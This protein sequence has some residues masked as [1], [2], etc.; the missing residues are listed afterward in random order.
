[1]ASRDSDEFPAEFHR[2]RREHGGAPQRLNDDQLAELAEEERVDAG[3]DDYDP[4]EVPPAT[5]TD[6]EPEDIRQTEVYEEE[7]A[8]LRR[9]IDNGEFREPSDRNPFPPTRYE[10]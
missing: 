1:M 4:D 3:V 5:D 6:P 10:E 7:R 8:E 2:N 9:E